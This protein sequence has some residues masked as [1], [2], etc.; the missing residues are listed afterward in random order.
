MTVL[1]KSFLKTLFEKA[2]LEG[3]YL[4]LV[5][6]LQS[7]SFRAF[8]SYLFDLPLGVPFIPRQ[9][10]SRE[11]LGLH[12]YWLIDLLNSAYFYR[13]IHFNKIDHDKEEKEAFVGPARLRDKRRQIK[14]GIP[15]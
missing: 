13:Q 5:S 9:Q 7:L 14:K 4:F 2:F 11:Y 6:Q 15:F 10:S 1:P 8:S 12:F 3:V